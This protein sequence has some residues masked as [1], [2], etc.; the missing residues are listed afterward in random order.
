[1]AHTAVSYIGK[2]MEAV[3]AG[4]D[5]DADLAA[6]MNDTSGTYKW[7]GKARKFKVWDGSIQ[8]GGDVMTSECPALTMDFD[9][10]SPLG[11]FELHGG[12]SCGTFD[13]V[14]QLV[15]IG[16]LAVLDLDLV[17][18]YHDLAVKALYGRAF[19]LWADPAGGLLQGSDQVIRNYKP[20]TSVPGALW[21]NPSDLMGGDNKPRLSYFVHRFRLELAL[22]VG[23]SYDA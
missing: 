6:F 17:M 9:E 7:R 11:D 8:P 1:M 5:A 16:H 2:A 19:R 4:I 13:A 14:L 18:K 23:P 15:L 12:G 10:G 3:W 20:L 21:V 22:P